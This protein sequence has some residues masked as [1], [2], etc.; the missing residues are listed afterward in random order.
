MVNRGEDNGKKRS[1]ALL[2][3]LNRRLSWGRPSPKAVNFGR[4]N[5]S[6]N[7][8][9]HHVVLQDSWTGVTDI[10]RSIWDTRPSVSR[11]QYLRS[12]DLP[13]D[14]EDSLPL[15]QKRLSCPAEFMRAAQAELLAKLE[16]FDL[17][18]MD[19]TSQRILNHDDTQPD[20]FEDSMEFEDYEVPLGCPIK[21]GTKYSS[22]PQLIFLNDE[23]KADVSPL[24]TSD[25]CEDE[26]DTTTNKE[27]FK[28]TAIYF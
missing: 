21:H 19:S 6:H 18:S 8:S 20:E 14:S 24:E 25:T 3:K 9:S 5:T 23:V 27:E 10:N 26:M 4:S 15:H 12:D 1:L 2:P 28:S 13:G 17:S 11:K 7:D 22:C 16:S